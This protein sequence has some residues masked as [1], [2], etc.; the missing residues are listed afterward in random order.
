[1][2]PVTLQKRLNRV[3]LIWCAVL[4]AGI[5]YGMICKTTSLGIPCILHEITGLDCPGCGMTRAVL[6]LARLDLAAAFGYNH[7]WPLIIGYLLWVGIGSSIAYVKRG[8]ICYLPGKIWVHAV[9]LT[10]VVAYG[11]LRNIL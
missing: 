8:E 1:M 4:L 7:L 2:K 3:L 9:L 11:V 6:A 10:A 5:G